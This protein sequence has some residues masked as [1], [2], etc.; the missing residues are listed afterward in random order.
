MIW[1]WSSNWTWDKALQ[2]YFIDLKHTVDT[3]LLSRKMGEVGF[4]DHWARVA[5]DKDSPQAA[6]A[7]NIT[8]A[9]K[10]VFSNT[11]TKSHWSNAEIAQGNFIDVIN[12]LKQ[13]AGNDL[14]VY[15]GATFVASLIK[16][17][18]IDE[19]YLFVNPTVL[20][21]GLSIFDA[22]EQ[23]QQLKLIEAKA[24][25]CGVLIVKYVLKNE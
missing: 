1:N 3:V 21:K 20:G 19:F 8:Q 5:A 7:K 25:D 14:I 15:G 16:A 10:V 12:S 9:H 6:F 24:F 22:I 11:I 4:M 23:R 17:Q 18:L 2:E 13:Q